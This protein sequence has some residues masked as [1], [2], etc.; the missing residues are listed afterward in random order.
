MFLFIRSE[1]LSNDK[2]RNLCSVSIH[3]GLFHGPLVQD[4]VKLKPDLIE[5][6][7]ARSGISKVF[8]KPWHMKR[9]RRFPKSKEA[10]QAK[11]KPVKRTVQ[12]KPAMATSHGRFLVICGRNQKQSLVKPLRSKSHLRSSSGITESAAESLPRL[13]KHV[14]TPN[15]VACSDS[16]SGLQK[17]VDAPKYYICAHIT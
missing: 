15:S 16:G 12:K 4:A 9:Q 3:H 14:D 13:R 2:C 5:A 1:T 11:C 6:D 8:G 7:G 10:P 17:A